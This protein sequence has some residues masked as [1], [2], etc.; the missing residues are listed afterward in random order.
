MSSTSSPPPPNLL[1]LLENAPAEA[2]ELANRDE[3]ARDSGAL[4]ELSL[5][6]D[7]AREWRGSKAESSRPPVPI[8][9]GDDCSP[10]LRQHG[11]CTAALLQ[12]PASTADS[13]RTYMLLVHLSKTGGTSLLSALARHGFDSRSFAWEMPLAL[14]PCATAGANCTRGC[15]WAER[16]RSYTA[17]VLRSGGFTS[18]AGFGACPRSKSKVRVLELEA[19]NARQVGVVNGQ[20]A[21]HAEP[22]F[23]AARDG[24]LGVV[25][26][27]YATILRPPVARTHSHMCEVRNQTA[28]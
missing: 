23:D 10:M 21:R 9:S 20:L 2:H 25:G 12:P 26:V 22:G 24:C 18:C 17:A 11:L 28:D 3:L 27:A 19:G 7:A 4:V 13:L 15:W 8:S 1:S 6:L 16:L 5:I 14:P